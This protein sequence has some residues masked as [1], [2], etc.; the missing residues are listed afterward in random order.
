MH[1]W[2]DHSGRIND[3]ACGNSFHVICEF[4]VMP[5]ITCAWEY[6]GN[7]VTV[8]CLTSHFIEDLPAKIP[9]LQELL[10]QG[11]PRGR[12]FDLR[13]EDRGQKICQLT[14]PDDNPD[15]N[16]FYFYLSKDLKQA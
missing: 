1:M 11:R 13:H 14:G 16:C 3:I 2:S 12:S 10:S 5:N 15:E 6:T 4:P 8:R 7:H 9:F